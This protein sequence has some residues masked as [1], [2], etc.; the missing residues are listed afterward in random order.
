VSGPDHRSLVPLSMAGGASFMTFAD[1]VAR[2]LA[3]PDVPVEI[4]TAIIGAPFFIYL[5]K[6][7]GKESW[8]T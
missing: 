1:T 6:R 4:I 2:S 7:G 3:N 8:G 5:M